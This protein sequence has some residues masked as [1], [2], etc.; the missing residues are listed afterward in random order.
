MNKYTII[1]I[2]AIALGTLLITQLI[3][4]QQL[5]V[6]GVIINAIGI[7]LMAKGSSLSTKKDKSEII[8]KIK[9]FR[10][11]IGVM[12]NNITNIES[13]EKIE[14]IQN[15]FNEWADNFVSDIE[16]KR[17]EQQKSEVLRKE[18]EIKLSKKWRHIYQ[19]AFEMIDNMLEAY[20]QR[21]GKRIECI[22]PELPNNLYDKDAESFKS[23][24]VFN[25]D[26]VWTIT[27]QIIKPYKKEEIPNIVIHFFFGESWGYSARKRAEK[28]PSR[29]F[30]LLDINLAGKCF[31]PAKSDLNL[32]VGDV[33]D[34]YSI[35]A[36]NYKTSIKDLF[37]TLF[38]YQIINLKTD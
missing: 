18:K 22:I 23:L 13:L 7:F 37:T 1:G 9:G 21:T 4:N 14:E 38:E 17:V 3:K 2:I 6:V 30:L 5:I 11:E 25:N 8:D 28:G 27:F 12:K 20:N 32:Y 35:S 29:E 26:T 10:E 16:S 31:H 19:Y 34:T 36:D 24:I 15:E 33:K